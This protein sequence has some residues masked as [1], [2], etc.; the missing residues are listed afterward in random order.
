MSG[1]SPLTTYEFER[2]EA[3]SELFWYTLYVVTPTLSV[4][5]FQVSV[6]ES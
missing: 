6:T 2:D 1:E 4:E 5:E 3:M